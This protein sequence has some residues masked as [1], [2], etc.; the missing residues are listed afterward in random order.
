MR[1]VTTTATVYQYSELSE[2]AKKSAYQRWAENCL[3]YEWWECTE[4]SFKEILSI[5][6]FNMEKIEFSGFSSQGDGASFFGSGTYKRGWKKAFHDAYGKTVPDGYAEIYRHLCAID[7]IQREYF[8]RIV[9]DI[10]RNHYCHYSHSRAMDIQL[11]DIRGWKWERPLQNDSTVEDNFR[12]L[13]DELYR[14]LEREYDYLRSRETF[15][16]F[17]AHE[18]EYTEEGEV[19]RD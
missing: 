16:D 5:F 12:L 3:D 9:V 19:Y 1:E 11:E 15:E 18:C 17:M 14:M 7:A 8:Y 2:T 6:G 4:E 13:A 10:K